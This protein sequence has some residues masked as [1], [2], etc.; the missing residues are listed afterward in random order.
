MLPKEIEEKLQE[1]PEFPQYSYFDGKDI[2][3]QEQNDAVKLKEMNITN[4]CSS[5]RYT[6]QQIE[7][8]FA[9]YKVQGEEHIFEESICRPLIGKQIHKPFFHYC[10]ICPKV[11]FLSLESIEHHSRY[12]DPELHKAKLLEMIQTEHR[13]KD[14]NKN[15]Q[16]MTIRT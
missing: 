9:S 6:I 16:D 2:E 15:G 8:F 11:E 3:K 12:K 4:S 14:E 10:K 7:E 5:Y 13:D 1:W